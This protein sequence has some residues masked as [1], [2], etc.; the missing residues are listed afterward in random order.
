MTWAILAL[1]QTLPIL[2][3]SQ[4]S[5][6]NRS[7][8]VRS[9]NSTTQRDYTEYHHERSVASAELG[10]NVREPR[11]LTP[12]QRCGLVKYEQFLIIYVLIATRELS[13]QPCKYNHRKNVPF[14]VHTP[15]LA[16]ADD[17]T[18]RDT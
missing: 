11:D 3:L 8:S 9:A 10:L 7:H 1:D 15:P 13:Y 2:A 12:F 18:S 4:T 16:P 5:K 14:E 17:A 6:F